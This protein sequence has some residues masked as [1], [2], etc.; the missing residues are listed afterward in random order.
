ISGNMVVGAL[1]NIGTDPEKV[2]EIMEHYGS[3]FGDVKV[4]I[5]EVN[6]SGI[7]ATFA[8]VKC[9]DNEPIAYKNL[10][11]NLDGIHH[12]NVN[13]HILKFAKNIFQTLAKAES[14][15]HGFDLDEIHFHE[16]GA[17]DAVADV[18][19][20]ALCFHELGFYEQKVY[21]LPT[22]LGGGRIK[23]KHGDLSVPAPATLEILK[24]IPV[25]GG[26]V[27]YELTTPTGAAI[28][29]NIV[30]EFSYFYPLITNR[31]IGYGAGKLD[32]ELPNILRIIKGDSP[33][34]T[35]KISIL[36]TNLDD[37]TG[38][39]L[40]HTFNRLLEVG[41]LDVT[42]IPTITKK[43]RPGQLLRVFTRPSDCDTVAEAI[44]RETGT[45]GIRV[46][47]YV[48][49]NIASRKIVPIKVVIK[50]KEE[51][52]R[53]K[54]GMIGDEIINYSPEFDDAKKISKET[55]LPL[56][57]VIKKSDM[58]FKDFIENKDEE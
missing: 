4:Q 1:V 6:K 49:R 11:K 34:K 48:H 19:G 29:V 17:A 23:I 20:A 32:L 31:R 38:E 8:D 9:S 46:M 42:V 50:G 21:G 25:V 22:A 7:S 47:P 16:V 40:G 35:D 2:T 54:V 58:A 43:N 39:V 53:I 26:P 55:G 56:K 33:V 57:D 45:L 18:M 5:R 15:I 44:I 28:M 36:E 41:A 3:H 30:D 13:S 24:N 37:V 51:D 52:I 12:K 14:K 27:E 10:L